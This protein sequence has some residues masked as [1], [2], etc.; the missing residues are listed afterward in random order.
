MSKTAVGGIAAPGNE[1]LDLTVFLLYRSPVSIG[2]CIAKSCNDEQSIYRAFDKH[3]LFY[4]HITSRALQ[5]QSC[6]I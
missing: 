4:I 3:G 1:M 2:K 6:L 5:Y